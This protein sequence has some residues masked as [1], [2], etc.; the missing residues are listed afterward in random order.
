MTIKSE[1]LSQINAIK[2]NVDLIYDLEPHPCGSISPMET[3]VQALGLE[4]ANLIRYVNE[5]L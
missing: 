1:I 2:K 4:I 3:Y 5:N